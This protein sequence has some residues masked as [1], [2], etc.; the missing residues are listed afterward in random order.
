MTKLSAKLAYDQKIA[1]F[2]GLQEQEARKL[3]NLKESVDNSLQ[4]LKTLAEKKS[5]IAKV[6]DQLEQKKREELISLDEIISK[7]DTVLSS[8]KQESK[9][10]TV[11]LKENQKL[12][13]KLQTKVDTLNVVA[14]ELDAFVKKESAARLKYLKQKEKLDSTEKTFK[15]S[16]AEIAKMTKDLDMRNKA[17]DNFKSYLMDFYGKIASYVAVARQTIEQVNI[18]LEKHE[19]PLGFKLPPGEILE[20]NIDNFDKTYGQT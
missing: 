8:I 4:E 13:K 16:K 2:R 9:K 12:S 20:I 10:E 18:D 19:V 7:K 1:E 14:N 11:V 5:A 6:I 17:M 15:D 3:Q